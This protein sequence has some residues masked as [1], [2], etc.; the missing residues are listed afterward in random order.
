MVGAELG[1]CLIPVEN[2]GYCIPNGRYPL[3]P[4]A[5]MSVVIAK[6]AGVK[7]AVVYSPAFHGCGAAHPAVLVAMDIVG[8][9]DIYCMGSA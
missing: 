7:N 3:P 9:D 8:T 1:Y 5:L 2:C 4:S 6:T